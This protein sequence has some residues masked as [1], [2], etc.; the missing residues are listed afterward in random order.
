MRPH[1]GLHA[2]SCVYHA[3]GQEIS[4]SRG[5]VRSLTL[6]IPVDERYNGMLATVVHC[7]NGIYE[8]I[9]WLI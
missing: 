3:L 2:G 5:F 7:D 9:P 8:S 6:T 1:T 4:L